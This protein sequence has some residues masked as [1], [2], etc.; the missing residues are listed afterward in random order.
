[1][2]S[3]TFWVQLVIVLKWVC[4]GLR[5][6][7]KAGTGPAV[8]IQG[9]IQGGHAVNWAVCHF[10]GSAGTCALCAIVD[11]VEVSNGREVKG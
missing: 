10:L 11:K 6:G 1:M 8:D 4:M 9:D 2:A 5:G 3:W 7:D